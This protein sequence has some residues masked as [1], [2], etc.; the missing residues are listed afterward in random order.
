MS[1]IR[2]LL[3]GVP[4]AILAATATKAAD[5][6]DGD[7]PVPPEQPRFSGFNALRGWYLRGDIGY[8]FSTATAETSAAG[9]TLSDDKLDGTASF[10][11]GG[12]LKLDWFRTDLT[13]DYAA[14]AKFHTTWNNGLTSAEASARI[15]STMVLAN[16]YI[17]LGTWYG[18]TPY[19][20]AGV[21]STFMRVS[22]YE[23]NGLP[24]VDGASTTGW[25]FTYAGMAGFAFAVSP[26]L[27]VDVGYRYL[28]FGDAPA[29]EDATGSFKAKD[30]ASHEV[31]LGLRWYF[32]D[33]GGFH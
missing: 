16:G 32:D 14:P 31:R 20:G 29:L 21:G 6:P 1:R 28:N 9:T 10:T 2:S 24:P 26:N 30:I 19:V 4:F 22:G 27:L 13:L 25:R 5:M 33:F 12:G 18:F 23:G 11:L 3:L 15:Q 8:R 17:D 7:Y